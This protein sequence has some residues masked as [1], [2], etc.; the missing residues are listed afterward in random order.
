MEFWSSFRTRYQ[1]IDRLLGELRSTLRIAISRTIMRGGRERK[2]QLGI[3]RYRAKIDKGGIVHPADC[4]G[5]H[6]GK[7]TAQGRTLQRARR[8]ATEE[9]QSET[10]CERNAV[11]SIRGIRSC[12]SKSQQRKK[13][14]G[15]KCRTTDDRRRNYHWKTTI[16]RTI[17]EREHDHVLY[18]T[19][20]LLWSTVKSFFCKSKVFQLK[21]WI[22]EGSF[23][24]KNLLNKLNL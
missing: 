8:I 16:F 15:I 3:L 17:V 14:S 9:A 19:Y 24:S 22:Y 4:G 2:R 5:F 7:G 1:S 20:L 12:F 21:K 13:F 11:Q 6:G 10:R 18:Y 23:Y